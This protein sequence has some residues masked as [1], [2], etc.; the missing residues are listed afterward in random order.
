MLHAV[1]KQRSSS[2]RAELE[3]SGFHAVAFRCSCRC[4][5][6]EGVISRHFGLLDHGQRVSGGTRSFQAASE[7]RSSRGN[8]EGQKRGRSQK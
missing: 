3:Q 1:P 2:A 4:A 5:Q 8:S 6:V 7:T